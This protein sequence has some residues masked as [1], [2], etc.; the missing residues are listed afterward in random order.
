[1]FEVGDLVRANEEA[2]RYYWG[3][4]KSE[5]YENSDYHRRSL[6]MGEIIQITSE[7]SETTYIIRDKINGYRLAMRG[8]T[9]ALVDYVI[10]EPLFDFPQPSYR[11]F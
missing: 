8:D 9:L 5:S 10:P 7:T 2:Q 11:H 6:R 1:V 4:D 3:R